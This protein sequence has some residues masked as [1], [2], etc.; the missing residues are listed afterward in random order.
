MPRCSKRLDLVDLVEVILMYIYICMYVMLFHKHEQ[1][2]MFFL[3]LLDS[4]Y[5]RMSNDMALV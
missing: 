1:F 2:P 4:I 3:I 5:S